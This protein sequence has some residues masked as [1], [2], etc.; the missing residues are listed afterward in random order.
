MKGFVITLECIKQ[1]VI[2]LGDDD[3]WDIEKCELVEAIICDD[4]FKLK[5]NEHCWYT[6]KPS[7]MLEFF[8]VAY[9]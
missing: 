3:L 2:D 6:L 1:V 5:I 4:G 7:A 8:K 9:K